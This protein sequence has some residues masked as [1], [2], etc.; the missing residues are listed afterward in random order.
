MTI[1]QQK[2]RI[3]YIADGMVKNFT[4]PF[5]FLDKQVAV[6][7]S[8]QIKPLIE[9]KDY[10]VKNNQN[11]SGG[12]IELQ[13]APKD[14]I[15][16]TIIRNVPLNQLVTF[17]EG[18]SFPA[19]DYETSLDKI[20]MS[21]Q[22]IEEVLNRTLKLDVTSSY[23][24]DELKTLIENINKDFDIIKKVPTL[25]SAINTLYEELLTTSTNVVSKENNGLITSS[26]VATHLSDNYYTKDIIDNA[27]TK[28]YGPI[29]IDTSTIIKSDTY[30][31]Y[32]Y[33]IDIILTDAKS[34]HTPT[35]ILNLN[36]AISDN[37]AP[38]AES[39]E[40]FVRVYLKN[41]PTNPS[42][43]IPIILLQ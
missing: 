25:A 27:I 4:V 19:R 11:T 1:Q 32:P 40:G 37:F 15:K 16:V 30:S 39:F 6:Y 33:H 7:L 29:S 5:Y 14:G 43:E 20:V 26:G 31:E 38:L 12:E 17:I 21:L 10:I 36:D 35:I 42:L 13:T 22:M 3:D 9:G 23:T 8:N 28:K 34:S 41:K 18:E 24:I 2:S